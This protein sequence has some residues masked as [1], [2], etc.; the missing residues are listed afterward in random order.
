MSDGLTHPSTFL[1]EIYEMLRKARQQTVATI[2][3]AMVTTYW[4]IGQRIVEEEQH[5]A[6]RANYGKRLLGELSTHLT[7]EFGRGFSIRNLENMRKFYL[8][9][10]T[11]KPIPQTVSAELA[12][13]IAKSQEFASRVSPCS[14]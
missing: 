9:Y 12:F 10:R 2:S 8:T 5:G 14:R 1:H 13:E 7:K 3:H 6:E 4:Q 11:R